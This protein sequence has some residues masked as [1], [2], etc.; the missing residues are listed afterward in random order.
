MVGTDDLRCQNNISCG[1]RDPVLDPNEGGDIAGY[2]DV[3]H[4][5][6]NITSYA[7]A[8]GSEA[9]DTISTLGNQITTATAGSEDGT[10]LLN[11][12]AVWN[13]ID[14]SDLFTTDCDGATRLVPWSIGADD[15]GIIPTIKTHLPMHGTVKTFLP[16]AGDSGFSTS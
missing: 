11:A 4:R 16:M 3:T 12:S 10:L 8:G 13:G 15:P 9:T 14:L 2:S 1:N 7:I 5:G 6:W